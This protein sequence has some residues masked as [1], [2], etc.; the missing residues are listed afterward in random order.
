[1]WE[2]DVADFK[3][4]VFIQNGKKLKRLEGSNAKS[5]VILEANSIDDI[6]IATDLMFVETKKL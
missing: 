5:T 3:M 2:T 1:V 4:P 6:Q